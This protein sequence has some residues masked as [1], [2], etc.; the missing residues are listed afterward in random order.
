MTWWILLLVLLVAV[1]AG[2]V[3]E[4]AMR[5]PG[6]GQRVACPKTEVAYGPP[7]KTPDWMGGATAEEVADG[8]RAAIDAMSHS[9]KEKEEK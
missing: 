3:L 8:I 5:K 4:W 6:G 2:I 7:G 9:L 1:P